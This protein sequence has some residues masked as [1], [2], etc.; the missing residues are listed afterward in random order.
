MPHVRGHKA[1]LD[2]LLVFE[3]VDGDGRTDLGMRHGQNQFRFG[4]GF[5]TVTVALSVGDH[6]LN[7][8]GVLVDFERENGLKTAF[9][10]VLFDGPFEMPVEFVDLTVNQ[11]RKTQNQRSYNFV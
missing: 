1:Q 8:V 4:T 10:I 6:R 11:M 7:D 9:V 3:T 5:K 2:H